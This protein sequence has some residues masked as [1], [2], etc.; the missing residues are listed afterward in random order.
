MEWSIQQTT[1]RLSVSSRALRYYEFLGMLKPKRIGRIR[2]YDEHQRDRIPEI[3][4]GRNL[5]FSLAEI[6]DLLD[7]PK[8]G[9]ADAP[10]LEAQINL[11]AQKKREID[12][13]LSQLSQLRARGNRDSSLPLTGLER[14]LEPKLGKATSN[15][16][17]R[18]E[19]VGKR[20]E[21]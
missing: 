20:V 2:Y 8:V 11:L 1:K 16:D 17:R 9:E 12:D 15:R 4:R 14:E 19:F 13:A 21:G 6:Q 3:L 5:G 7:R 18:P 10:N